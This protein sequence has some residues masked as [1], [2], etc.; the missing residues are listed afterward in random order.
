M[1]IYSNIAKRNILKEQQ[2]PEKIKNSYCTG[3]FYGGAEIV[4]VAKDDSEAEK[5]E[6]LLIAD[7][8][9]L[10]KIKESAIS[11]HNI[12]RIEYDG[13]DFTL[14]IEETNCAG[15][16]CIK[17]TDSENAEDIAKNI[18]ATKKDIQE[19]STSYLVDLFGD[20]E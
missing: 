9:K 2:A 12:G 16:E 18:E 8:S 1:G 14:V 5:F 11:E 10:K 20:D 7:Y 4:V 19:E 6:K 3:K 13:K 15:P 17:V